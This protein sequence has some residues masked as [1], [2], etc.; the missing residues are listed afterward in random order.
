LVSA[1]EA[2]LCTESCLVNRVGVTQGSL[3]SV[4]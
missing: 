2:A 3:S 4:L 1:V